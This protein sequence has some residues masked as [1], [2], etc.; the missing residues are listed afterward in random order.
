M[1]PVS[2]PAPKK[3]RRLLWIGVAAV[4]VVLIVALVAY[5]VIGNS[6][7]D[8]A[9]EASPSPTPEATVATKD[10]VKQDLAVLDATIKQASTDHTA[11]KA[12]LKD[13]SSQIKV[14]N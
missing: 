4:V 12:A 1:D 10:E 7:K 2:A 6:K 13:Q 3:S 9:T 11:A 8:V 5:L 14:G